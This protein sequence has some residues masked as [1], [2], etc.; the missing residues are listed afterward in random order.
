MGNRVISYSLRGIGVSLNV[1]ICIMR[2]GENNVFETIYIDIYKFCRF[3]G[4]GGKLHCS[5][6]IYCL[7][8]IKMKKVQEH[9]LY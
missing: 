1:F 3:A 5:P 4:G 7:L 6:Y 2:F 8:F 9:D